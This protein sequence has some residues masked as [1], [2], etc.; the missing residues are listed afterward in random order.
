MAVDEAVSGLKANKASEPRRWIAKVPFAAAAAVGVPTAGALGNKSAAGP[1]QL[2]GPGPPP[3]PAPTAAL[4]AVAKAQKAVGVRAPTGAPVEANRWAGEEAKAGVAQEAQ[5]PAAAPGFAPVAVAASPA[6]A[7][8][9]TQLPP[10]S[11]DADKVRFAAE[12]TVFIFDWDDTVLP[13]TW[14]QFQG[15]RLD[16]ASM[17]NAWQ[18]EELGKVAAAAAETLRIAKQHGTVVLVTNAERGWIELSCQKFMPTLLPSLENVKVL[19]ARSTYETPE[20]SS[21]LD[22]KLRAFESEINRIYGLEAKHEPEGRKNVLS[23]GD[24][25]HEREALLQAT[26][27]LPNCRSKSLKFVER[28]DIRQLCKQ[29]SLV[30]SCF[31][32]IVH[33]DGNLDLCIR[34]A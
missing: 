27:T 15:L 19:S 22:W 24:S 32:Q 18:Q 1:P 12:E 34:C 6:P 9:A 20:V 23:L 25:F 30:T 31:D 33:H 26:N 17:V 4:A 29:H 13:S 5:A 8:A 16:D 28:P 10:P 11:N 21:P 7:A 14:V 2:P 3:P